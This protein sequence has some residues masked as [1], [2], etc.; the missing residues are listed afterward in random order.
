MEFLNHLI[1]DV[2]GHSKIED[3]EWSLTNR[4][5]AKFPHLLHLD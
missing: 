4:L 3:S 1:G 2:S 5:L